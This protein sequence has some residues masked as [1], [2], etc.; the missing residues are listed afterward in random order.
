V[1]AQEINFIVYLAIKLFRNHLTIHSLIHD[2]KTKDQSKLV[3]FLGSET[4]M[5]HSLIFAM[6]IYEMHFV[7]CYCATMN[8]ALWPYQ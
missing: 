2:A 4:E 3:W 5:K 1:G 6:C 8:K 7:A